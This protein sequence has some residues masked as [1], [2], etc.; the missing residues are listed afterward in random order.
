MKLLLAN[1]KLCLLSFFKCDFNK[2]RVI[3]FLFI[4]L[5]T[6]YAHEKESPAVIVSLIVSLF[7]FIYIIIKYIL[8]IGIRKLSYIYIN[9]QEVIINYFSLFEVKVD[10]KDILKNRSVQSGDQFTFFYR[11]RIFKNFNLLLLCTLVGY[12]ISIFKKAGLV[13]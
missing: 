11:K 5:G 2:N 8:R 10:K 12:D 6:F 3:Y 7:L 9:D 13:S 1:S 4:I